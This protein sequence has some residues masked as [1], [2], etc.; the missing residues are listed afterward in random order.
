MKKDSNL[1]F[2]IESQHKFEFACSFGLLKEIKNNY[3][4]LGN[5]CPEKKKSTIV[6]K[7]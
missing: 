5:L 4:N 7:L 2:N 6:I 3:I 1:M